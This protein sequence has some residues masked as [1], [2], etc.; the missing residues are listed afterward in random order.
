MEEMDR[1]LTK[2]HL[3]LETIKDIL[4]VGQYCPG[5]ICDEVAKIAVEDSAQ[6]E[7][8]QRTLA[9]WKNSHYIWQ[10]IAYVLQAGI[11]EL[12]TGIFC[13]MF[14]SK[15]YAPLII[16]NAKDLPL[17]LID[18]LLMHRDSK[19][20]LAAAKWCEG[21][22]IPE[23]KIEEWRNLD[24]LA[25]RIAAIFTTIGKE[26]P[27]DHPADSEWPF[28]IMSDPVGAEAVYKS[29][30]NYPYGWGNYMLD[31]WYDYSHDTCKKAGPLLM[32]IASARRGN[33]ALIKKGLG[34]YDWNTQLEAAKALSGKKLS[35]N[36]ITKYHCSDKFT[37]RTAAMYAAAGRED[38]PRRWIEE[39]FTAPGA[40]AIGA[41]YAAH[42]SGFPPYRAIEPTGEVFKQCLN[43][44]IIVAEI[45][46]DAEIRGKKYEGRFRSDKAKIVDIIGD[47]YGDD[48]GIS[49]YDK[50]TKYRIGDVIAVPDF[51]YSTETHAAGFHFCLTRKEAENNKW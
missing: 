2:N 27:A 5:A 10:N 25:A 4:T 6:H 47:F 43:G 46:K 9:K 24:C 50:K 23:E 31:E 35:L 37:L 41:R 36:T 38:V 32:R 14:D 28:R 26:L 40:I 48:I 17:N 51:N 49:A 3:R 21:K 20:S 33:V 18:E 11:E 44:V 29:F 45:P 13:E 30:K 42:A 16:E 12:E 22:N 8:N 1:L 15:I 39:S 34:S 7:I 19:I